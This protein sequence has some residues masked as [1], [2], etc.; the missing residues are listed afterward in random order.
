MLFFDPEWRVFLFLN[1]LFGVKMG[2]KLNL[3]PQ[4]GGQGT[5][6]NLYF[7]RY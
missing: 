2:G 5:G 1:T 7:K 4:G 3:I 6:Y